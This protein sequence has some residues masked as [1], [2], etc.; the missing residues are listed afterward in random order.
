MLINCGGNS[1]NRFKRIKITNST[2]NKQVTSGGI[3]TRRSETH[4]TQ[5]TL[6]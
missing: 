1:M 3:Q 6:R 4:P 2:I 5:N